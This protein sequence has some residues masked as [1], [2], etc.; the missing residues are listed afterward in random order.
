M[1]QYFNTLH[2]ETKSLHGSGHLYSTG[3]SIQWHAIVHEIGRE[4]LGNGNE[5][6]LAE[7]PLRARTSEFGNQVQFFTNSFP[8]IRQF[9]APAAKMDK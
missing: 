2:E 4:G 1:R 7:L 8:A 3:C 5:A 9:P 6:A